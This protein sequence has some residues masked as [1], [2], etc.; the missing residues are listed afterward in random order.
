MRIALVS[1]LSAFSLCLGLASNCAAQANPIVPLAIPTQPQNSMDPF[2]FH[3]TAEH[4]QK[5]LQ[6]RHVL[7][8]RSAALEANNSCGH[9]VIYEAAPSADQGMALKVPKDSPSNMPIIPALPVCESDLRKS[10][11]SFEMPL[12]GIVVH[13]RQFSTDG[14]SPRPQ[15]KP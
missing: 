12:P 15:P 13:P 4:L 2:K 6:A 10:T 8:M 5:D 9:L 7:P 3:I 11:T 1:A 14:G